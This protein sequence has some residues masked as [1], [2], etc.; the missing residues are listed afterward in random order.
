MDNLANILE[1]ILFCA[2]DPIEKS[3]IKEKL[4][5]TEKDLNKAITELEE[6]FNKN[7][8]GIILIKFNNKLQFASNSIYSEKIDLVLKKTKERALSKTIMETLA[9][10]AYKQPV[11][12]L[13]IENIRGG[14]PADYALRA[15]LEHKLITIVGRKESL[16]RPLLF[17]T[18][19]EFL[20]RF[21]LEN[22]T[23][24]PDFENLINQ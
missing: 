22:L 6:K 2:G 11:T 21:D 5:I 14:A 9:I 7:E 13:E 23:Q 18:T 19:D 24:L 1:G 12:R 4:E 17:G 16:G 15:L 20:K 10:I 3:L 8:S